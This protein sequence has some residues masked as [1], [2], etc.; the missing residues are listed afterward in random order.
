MDS[1]ATVTQLHRGII[2]RKLV[3]GDSEAFLDMSQRA[4]CHVTTVLQ[5][6]RLLWMRLFANFTVN[7]R[8]LNYGT[9]PRCARTP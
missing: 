5:T 7:T 2:K 3:V 1:T 6:I 8:R 4:I 9:Q